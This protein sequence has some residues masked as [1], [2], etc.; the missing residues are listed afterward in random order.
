MRVAITILMCLLAFLLIGGVSIQFKPFSFSVPYWHRPVV[1]FLM[2]IALA[3]Y[4]VGEHSSG[5]KKGLSE[6]VDNLIKSLKE[7]QDGNKCN[8]KD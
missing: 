5:Y 8:E 3:V 4:S 2:F 7:N 1:V 6:G